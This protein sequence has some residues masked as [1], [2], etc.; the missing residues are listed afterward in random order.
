MILG[1]V[2][3]QRAQSFILFLMICM[4]KAKGIYNKTG[5]KEHFTTSRFLGKHIQG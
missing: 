2:G 5:E 3:A 4:A 1:R